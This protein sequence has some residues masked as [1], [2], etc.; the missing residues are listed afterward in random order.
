VS[1]DH[2][3]D[4]ISSKP[5]YRQYFSTNYE[6][7]AKKALNINKYDIYFIILN[8]ST[9]WTLLIGLELIAHVD[10]LGGFKS[11]VLMLSKSLK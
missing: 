1:L 6:L 4:L 2:L 11:R 9:A 5:L 8:Q 7:K 3:A 10:I